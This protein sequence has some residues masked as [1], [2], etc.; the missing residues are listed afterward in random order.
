VV[1]DSLGIFGLLLFDV[2]VHPQVVVIENALSRTA[3]SV[4]ADASMPLA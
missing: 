3:K 1:L 2:G 4:S